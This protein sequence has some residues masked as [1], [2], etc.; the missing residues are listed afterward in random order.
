MEH[1]A[2]K[3]Q[4]FLLGFEELAQAVGGRAWSALPG[5]APAGV[6]IDSR[7][8]RP[9]DLYVAIAGERFDG[10]DFIGQALQAGA[11]GAVVSRPGPFPA[12]KVFLEVQDT[13][14]A[15]LGLAAAFR[16]KWGGRLICVTGSAGK[17]TTKEWIASIL[18][19]D[20]AVHTS[21][22]NFNN[23][24]GLSLTLLALRPEC[25]RAVV[26]IGMNHA[27]EISALAAAAAPDVGVLTCVAPVHL[28]FFT[29]LE[30]IADAKAEMIPFLP[31]NGCLVYNADDPLLGSRAATYPGTRIS[32]GTSESA[33]VRATE[34]RSRGLDGSELLVSWQGETVPAA[35][36][37]PG[38]HNIYNL[39][40]A[41]AVAAAEGRPLERI[42][43]AGRRE[44][45][46]Y[47]RGA[48]LRFADGFTVIDDSYNS[49]PR[50]LEFM[51][52]LI[53][54]TTGYRRK[55]VVA[56]EMKEL[57]SGSEEW[58]R[59]AG[60]CAARSGAELL[61]GVQGQARF[62]LEGAREAGMAV[63][64]TLWAENAAEAAD[65]LMAE[66]RPGDL[67]LIKGSRG[68][69]LDQVVARLKAA[70]ALEGAESASGKECPAC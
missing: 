24:I 55:V 41:V 8:T 17:T 18:S 29:S 66:L 25:R 63:A 45:A 11:C 4:G 15:L 58:H 52:G 54:E 13:R 60:R 69:A 20:E 2:D 44:P 26:E 36:P 39:L 47:H 32:F 62:L 7:T 42:V 3:S 30:A 27:G 22:G 40:A 14:L 16:R 48:R 68:V 61:L 59:Q 6:S 33:D 34:I 37:L 64:R 53:G 35:C 38:K 23:E 51:L 5:G 28:E 46:V 70:Y 67:V 31:G 12:D 50:A 57:G 65:R 49:N 19:V 1:Q 43:Q 9:G 56:G 10:H 21:R